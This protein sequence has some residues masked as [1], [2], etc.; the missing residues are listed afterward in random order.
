MWERIGFL[1]IKKIWVWRRRILN[2][3]D[4]ILFYLFREVSKDRIHWKNQIASWKK[5]LGF[6]KPTG[7][8]W[9]K[10]FTPW[11]NVM[12]KKIMC[13]DILK[14]KNIF[15]PKQKSPFWKLILPLFSDPISLPYVYL[16][17]G[18]SYFLKEPLNPHWHELLKQEKYSSLAPPMS[19]FCKTR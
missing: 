12:L 7:T 15:V 19:I 2:F 6:K 16:Q 14:E 9:K 8:S 11:L 17:I 18:F 3:L 1:V 4:R 10:R 13:Q 5:C